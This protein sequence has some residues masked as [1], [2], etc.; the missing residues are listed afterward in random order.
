M[1]GDREILAAYLQSYGTLGIFLIYV[2]LVIQV[3][4]ATIPGQAIMVTGGYLY[5]F[6][7]GLVV[8]YTSTVITSQF[9]YEL[10][11]RY[12]RPLVLKLAPAEI[13][14]KWAVR[15]ERQ[16]IP[17]FIFSFTTP[18]F[19]ADVM[20]FVAGLSGLSG[21]KF[22]IANVIGRLPSAIVFT[23]IGSHGLG[24]PLNWMIAV[25]ITITL[26]ALFFWLWIGPKL[27]RKYL[28]QQS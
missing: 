23:L 13:V 16:G 7:I 6:W 4:I 9:C 1:I 25:F 3:I 27:E 26:I 18:I 12:G 22:L 8:S 15:A 5:G 11:R 28:E 19:P 24:L 21:R 17:F 14:D 20:N 2:F 10:A